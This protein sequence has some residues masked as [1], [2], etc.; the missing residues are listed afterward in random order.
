MSRRAL[1][2]FG[3]SLRSVLS[4]SSSVSAS[5]ARMMSTTASPIA[6][7]V[8]NVNEKLVGAGKWFL[9]DYLGSMYNIVAPNVMKGSKVRRLGRLK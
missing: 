8:K 1:S 6:E 3:R 9:V 4:D 7:S 5:S 2:T